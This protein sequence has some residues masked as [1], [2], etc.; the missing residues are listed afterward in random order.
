MNTIPKEELFTGL[1]TIQMDD[2][3]RVGCEETEEHINNRTKQ[4]G[5]KGLRIFSL[6][7]TLSKRIYICWVFRNFGN[8]HKNDVIYEQNIYSHTS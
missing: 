3:R 8:I 7:A 2:T 5:K 4:S 1:T 6:I